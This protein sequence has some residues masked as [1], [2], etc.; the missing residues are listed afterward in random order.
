MPATSPPLTNQLS[1]HEGSL[2]L[3]SR[4]SDDEEDLPSLEVLVPEIHLAQP[5]ISASTKPVSAMIKCAIIFKVYCPNRH[6]S[7]KKVT[8]VAIQSP[9]K[10]TYDFNSGD[11]DWPAFKAAVTHHCSAAT[12]FKSLPRIFEDGLRSNPPK[13]TWGG[14]VFRNTDWPKDDPPA[15]SNDTRFPEWIRAM[16]ACKAK[17]V[18]GG[19]IIHMA[20][21]RDKEI[22]AEKANLVDRTA[23]R[24]EARDQDA[25]AAMA[26]T[27]A[28]TT[29]DAAPVPSISNALEDD[30]LSGPDDELNTYE[31]F[32]NKDIHAEQIF[33]KYAHN[34]GYDRLLTAYL[35]PE[36]ADRY[37]L[38]SL[39]NVAVWAKAMARGDSGVDLL[40]PPAGL[41]YETRNAKASAAPAG[42]QLAPAPETQAGMVSLATVKEIIDMCMTRKRAASPASSTGPESYPSNR[43]GSLEDYL[44][45]AGV[46]DKEATLQTL[47]YHGINQYYLFK[48]DHLTPAN[49]DELGLTMGTLAK[50][51]ANVTRYERSLAGGSTS[52]TTMN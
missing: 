13:I 49:L 28:S 22:I 52:R 3:Y 15:I 26:S 12:A 39:G 25:R 51:R 6:K 5:R 2:P 23:S 1:T 24:C 36:N 37:I 18:K 10:L 40:S 33:Q 4:G 8:W 17:G 34:T 9:K 45:F 47:A 7:T 48:P 27:S 11:V 32:T 30:E 41:R 14:Y 20:N 42:G 21:P 50:L 38:L 31:E 46:P 43:R 35:D 16:V 29:T 44:S 19:V